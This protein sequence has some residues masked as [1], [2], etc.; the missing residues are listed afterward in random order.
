MKG[1]LVLIEDNEDVRENTA[2]I[3]ELDGYEVH[4]APD[5][6]EGVRLVREFQPDLIICDIMMPELDGYG[7]LHMLNKDPKTA[8]IPFIF[9]TAKA[10]RED[11]RK[12]MNLGADDYITKPFDE[13]Q[14]LH[15]VEMRLSKRRH[16][17][18]REIPRNAEGLGH[19]I[20][21]AK[22]SGALQHLSED[23]EVRHLRRR[24]IIYRE[25]DRPRYL[26][27]LQSGKVK[28]FRNSEDGKEYITDLFRPGDFFGI[29]AL[30]RETTYG[31]T[32]EVLEDAEICLIPADDYYALIHS[33]K[34]VAYRFIQ[35]LANHLEETEERLVRQAYD[36]VRKRVADGLLLLESRYREQGNS[37]PFSMHI[38]RDD[39]AGIV[40]TAKE[41]VIRTLTDFRHEG[42]V[43][44]GGSGEI[45]IKNHEGLKHIIA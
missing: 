37:K 40:G 32:A 43:E 26:Y 44:I 10:E 1:I 22:T 45:V 28:A 15:A 18:E 17:Q 36:S 13:L 3:L 12:G 8:H 9:L 35:L 7:V 34:D 16:F 33:D 11:F 25:G 5:G 21:D 6:K 2:E 41:T 14:L 24:E 19:F 30:M 27:L 42:L 31:D 39:L 38:M 4:S 23:R 20:S 29:S